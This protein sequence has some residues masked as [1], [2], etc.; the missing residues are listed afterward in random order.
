MG[1]YGQTLSKDTSSSRLVTKLNI[2]DFDKTIFLSPDK[3]ADWP[4]GMEFGGRPESVGVTRDGKVVVP[5]KPGPE[6]YRQD[7]IEAA[8]KCLQDKSARTILMTGRPSSLEQRIREITE[9]VGLNFHDQVYCVGGGTVKPKTLKWILSKPEN[10]NINYVEAWDDH[11]LGILKEAIGERK[12]KGNQYNTSDSPPHQYSRSI[13]E[14][15]ESLKHQ[16]M[17]EKNSSND[18]SIASMLKQ[19][20]FR[21]SK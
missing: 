2:F 5:P 8:K 15:L 10:Q 11:D 19:V 3:P 16:L 9:N 21:I 20:A 1:L 4:A 14:G 12:W 18:I 6:W 7:V 13:A 17:Q